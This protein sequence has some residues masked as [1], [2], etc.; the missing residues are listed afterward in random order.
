MKRTVRV[1]T[2][3]NLKT[4]VTARGFTMLEVM[5]ALS[6]TTVLMMIG[7]A[8]L[9]AG[10]RSWDAAA[11]HAE[12]LEQRAMTAEFL[13]NR[14]A[15]ALPVWDDFSAERRSFSFVGSPDTLQFVAFPAHGAG[16]GMRY[17][18]VVAHAQG[19]LIVRAEPFARPLLQFLPE[20]LPVPLLEGVKGLRLAYFGRPLGS[21]SRAPQWLDQ[22]SSNVLP[23]LVR[24][25]V[26]DETGVW[27]Q[28]IPIRQG[29]R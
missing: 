29:G 12:R 25:T 13:A 2:Q 11:L 16:Q 5:L 20:A 22:W 4:L 21:S 26:E 9:R 10:T 6:I 14:L 15:A 1:A 28:L 27:S 3:M 23:A 8:V 17:R 19:V 24:V 18:F 7:F